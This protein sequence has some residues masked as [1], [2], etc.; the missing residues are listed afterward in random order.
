[1]GEGLKGGNCER[2]GFVGMGW[3]DFGI[4]ERMEEERGSVIRLSI[5]SVCSVPRR[6]EIGRS[7]DHGMENSRICVENLRSIA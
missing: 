7:G 1:V 3:V 6:K 2:K 4:G 5:I